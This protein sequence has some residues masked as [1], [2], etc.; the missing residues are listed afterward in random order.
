MSIIF[1][2]KVQKYKT[3]AEANPLLRENFFKLSFPHFGEV[4]HISLTKQNNI[5]L[6]HVIDAIFLETS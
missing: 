4:F 1:Y 3:V 2:T 5:C 6:S